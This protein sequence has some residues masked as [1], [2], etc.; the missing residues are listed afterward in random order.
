MSMI[1]S[2]A[3]YYALETT[4]TVLWWSGGQLVYLITPS[5]VYNWAFPTKSEAQ[6]LRDEIKQLRLEVHELNQHKIIEEA[7]VVS[8]TPIKKYPNFNV[9][10]TE[11]KTEI[12]NF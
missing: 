1:W 10:P 6:L 9:Y 12:V 3:S 2:V 8:E 5:M 7:I 11:I 4:K